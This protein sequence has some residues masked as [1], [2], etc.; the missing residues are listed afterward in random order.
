MLSDQCLPARQLPTARPQ[1]YRLQATAEPGNGRGTQTP[2]PHRVGP[3]SSCDFCCIHFSSISPPRHWQKQKQKRPPKATNYSRSRRDDRPVYC[4]VVSAFGRNP[5]PPR[6]P[7]ISGH[8]RVSVVA[9]VFTPCGFRSQG[10]DGCGTR[11]RQYCHFL[12]YCG[13]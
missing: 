9:V 8:R 7:I 12:L 4:K 11:G 2:T 1:R 3:I 13:L 6:P 5:H 10:T